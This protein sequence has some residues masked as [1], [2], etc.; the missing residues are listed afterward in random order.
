V[1][2]EGVEEVI[3]RDT[4]FSPIAEIDNNIPVVDEDPDILA[5]KSQKIQEKQ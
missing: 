4:S 3:E 2:V 1:N 5:F